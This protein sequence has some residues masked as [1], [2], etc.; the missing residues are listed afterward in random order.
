MWKRKKNKAPVTRELNPDLAPPLPSE[1]QHR[2]PTLIR[3][4]TGIWSHHGMVRAN[5]EDAW[6][7][8][9]ESGTHVPISCLAILCDGMG[10][11]DVG[12]KASAGAIEGL[13]P[14]LQ[15]LPPSV[16]LTAVTGAVQQVNRTLYLQFQQADEQAGTTLTGVR[17]TGPDVDVFHAGDSRLYLIKPEEHT[18]RQVTRDHSFVSRLV[19]LGH[20]T[21]EEARTH[22][23]K[24]EIYNMVGLKE[25]VTPDV[26]TFTLQPGEELLLC[27]DG[28]VDMVEDREILRAV[29]S[30][31]AAQSAVERLGRLANAN[32]GYDNCTILYLK[33]VWH[34]PSH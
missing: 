30:E 4:E 18:I 28:L 12:E 33:P 24:N 29:L 21:R 25:D 7:C 17:L 31:T 14:L 11:L 10:G 3:L 6:Y 9:Q 27:S 32:G 8:R 13:L 16:D 19:E 5:N 34:I 23:R 22:P 15:A 2:P 1:G 20:I 26:F